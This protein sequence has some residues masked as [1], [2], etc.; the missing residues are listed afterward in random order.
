MEG[1]AKIMR[2]IARDEA[3][4]QKGTQSKI[5]LW[6]M[7][8]DDP[9]MAEIAYQY[10]EEATKIFLEVYEQEKEWAEHLFSIGDVDGVSLKSTIAYI[11]HLTDQRMRAVGLQSPFKPTP[12]PYP[13]MNKWL[14]SDNVQVA[15]QEVEVSSYLVGNLNTE[16][17]DEA[18]A[19]WRQKYA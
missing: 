12:N 1:N 9:E 13:W 11:E 19:K 3:L 2:L 6:Q 7:G 18:Y 8:K 5:R 17:S 16:I 15:P 10:E 4:H 14:K